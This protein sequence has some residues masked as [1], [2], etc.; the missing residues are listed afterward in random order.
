MN[1]HSPRQL[2]NAGKMKTV[3]F[4]DEEESDSIESS[5]DDDK[6]IPL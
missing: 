3:C 5:S 2:K 1:N 4:K 6:P